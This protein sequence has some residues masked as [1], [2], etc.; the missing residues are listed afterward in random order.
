MKKVTKKELQ[1]L[2]NKLPQTFEIQKKSVIKYGWELT[3]ADLIGIKQVVLPN[4]KYKHFHN[5]FA[6][7]NHLSRLQKAYARSKDKGVNEYVQWVGANNRML[8]ERFKNNKLFAENT[9]EQLPLKGTIAY[10]IYTVSNWFAELKKDI[11]SN[12]KPQVKWR[13]PT[14]SH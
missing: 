8:N 5:E 4:T 12:F 1:I 13:I 14:L 7:V 6:S 2:A 10:L 9:L 3:E 11:I